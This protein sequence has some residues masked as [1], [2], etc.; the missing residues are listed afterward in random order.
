MKAIENILVPTDFSEHSVY[1]LGYAADLAKR[2]S[3]KITLV[4]VYPVVNFAAAEGF[5]LYTPEQ[6]TALLTELSQQLKAAE[7]HVR[8]EGVDAVQST[9]VQGDAFRELV[10]LSPKFDLVVI[11]THGR[12]GFKHALIGSVAEKLVRSASCPVLTVRKVAA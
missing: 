1:A 7:A 4:H 6:L 12:T 5:S 3:A 11:G 8:A 2:Y 10:A 9:L